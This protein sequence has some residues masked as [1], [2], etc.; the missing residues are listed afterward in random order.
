MLE[1]LRETVWKANIDLHKAGLV[2]LTWGN[3]SGVDPERE[4]FIIK[5][6]GVPYD[7]L[8]PGHLVIVDFK[9][10]IVEGRLRPSSDTPTHLHLY[11]TFKGIG[12]IAHTH[13]PAATAFAQACRQIPCLG[14]THADH[15]HGPVPVTRPLSE[16]E[17]TSE[18]ELNTGKVIT[19]R[20]AELDPV[21]VPAVLVAQHGP[22]SWGRDAGEA[23]RNCIALE[24]VAAMAAATLQLAPSIPEIPEHLLNLHYNR[25]HGPKATYGQNGKH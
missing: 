25:K 23:V 4:V 18:Y 10:K 11:R 22:F 13:S 15:F 24:M 2:T 6:S 20:F 21:A 8:Q 19:E 14:T 1:A 3:V 7:D 5:P 16:R 12:G 9:G 17:V